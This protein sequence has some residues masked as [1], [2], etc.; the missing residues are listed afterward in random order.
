MMKLPQIQIQSTDMKIAL[1][2]IK[3]VQRIEQPKPVMEIE[4]PNADVKIETSPGKLTIDQSKAWAD[5]GYKSSAIITEEAATK[6][7]QDAMSGIE[8]R[9]RQGDEMMKIEYGGNPFASQAIENGNKPD[10]QFNIGWIPSPGSVKLH[11]QPAKVHID[12][13]EN[14]PQITVQQQKVIHDYTPGKVDITIEQ[15]NS[16]KIDFL[17]LFEETI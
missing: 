3:S 15:W 6:G 7:M 5:M 17:H 9:R 10:M 2:T 8:R 14:K 12:V 13:Q 4:Q 16:L 1:H 11:Y